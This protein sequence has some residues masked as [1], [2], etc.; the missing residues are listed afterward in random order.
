MSRSRSVP[1][2]P[3]RS[4]AVT[5]EL[6]EEQ[7]AVDRMGGSLEDRLRWVLAFAERDL[8]ALRSGEWSALG[9]DLRQLL[10]LGWSTRRRQGIPVSPAVLRRIQLAVRQGIHNLLADARHGSA[11]LVDP[12]SG[13]KL[14]SGHDQIVRVS[15]QGS[16]LASFQL[17]SEGD[18]ATTIVRGIAD[19]VL[20][21]GSR[22]RLCANPQCGRPFVAVKRQEYCT[23]GCS[24]VVRN[25]AKKKRV[26]QKRLHGRAR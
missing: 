13:W 20:R 8:G 11:Q 3:E 25:E 5:R 14:P 24:Q 12:R 15:P 23:T 17:V 2:V 10:P 19:L 21:A 1:L 9:Y 16:R 26:R 4:S 22:L 7:L 18:D 6:N